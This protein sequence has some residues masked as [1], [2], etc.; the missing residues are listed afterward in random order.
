MALVSVIQ[1]MSAMWS[2]LGDS[3][4]HPGSPN[5]I[6]SCSPWE[7]RS[8]G[9]VL[10]APTQANRLRPVAV[11]VQEITDFRTNCSKTAEFLVKEF[12][13]TASSR[14]TAM[15]TTLMNKAAI[16]DQVNL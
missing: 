2:R 3:T 10:S 11:Y 5:T 8:D 15:A 1:P 9:R 7:D 12:K 4:A 16:K 13:Q 6:T 14:G